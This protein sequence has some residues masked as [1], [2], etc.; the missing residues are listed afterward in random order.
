MWPLIPKEARAELLR[1]AT[2][3]VSAHG[4][5]ELIGELAVRLRG[6]SPADAAKAAAAI[7]EATARVR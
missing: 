2:E 7:R 1:V 5:D 4:I 3:A 6:L